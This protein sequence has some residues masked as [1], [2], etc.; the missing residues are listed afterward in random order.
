MHLS[1]SQIAG[2]KAEI[3]RFYQEQG[4]IFA[5]R[6][7]SNPYHIVVSEI[8]LQQTQT[9]RVAPKYE[10]FIMMFPTWQ[11]LAQASTHDVLSAW[12]GLGYNRRALS[13]HAIAKRVVSEFEGVLVNDPVLLVQ[14]PG[15]GKATAASICAFAYNRPTIFIETNIRAVFIYFFFKDQAIIGD[16]QILPL[17][18]QTVDQDKPRHWY[19][20]LMDYGVML[21][22]SQVNPSRKSSHY[23]KQ[24]RFEGS[25]RQIRGAIIR[26]LTQQKWLTREELIS[27]LS[28]DRV[29]VMAQL[30]ALYKEGFIEYCAGDIIMLRRS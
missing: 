1:E 29:R 4:R 21:K 5:W 23:T 22:K 17:V 2:F 9:Y 12:Q 3:W 7:T 8:M 16:D 13:L 26:L 11:A 28:F 6:N 20:A 30:D 25:D 14:F 15:I 18:T 27:L 10:L 19:Y 24:S